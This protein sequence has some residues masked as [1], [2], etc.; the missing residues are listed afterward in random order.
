MHQI[1]VTGL[2]A[3]AEETRASSLARRSSLDKITK[4]LI[5]GLLCYGLFATTV[6]AGEEAAPSPENPYAA[7]VNGINIPLWTGT[8]P[9]W[10]PKENNAWLPFLQPFILPAGKSKGLVIVCPG[11][12][13]GGLAGH[14]GGDVAKA[15]NNLGFSAVVLHYRVTSQHQSP[16]GTGPLR[17]AGRAIRIVRAHA[18]AWGTTPEK[19]AILGFSAGGHLVGSTGVLY[20]IPDADAVNDGF[21]IVSSRP[22]AVIPCYAVLLSGEF[23][24]EG[25]M[26]NL[27]GKDPEKRQKFDIPSRVTAETPPHFIWHTAEDSAVPVENALRMADALRNAK[28]TFALHVF[29]RG[30]HG[31]GLGQNNPEAKVWPFMAATWLENVAF[32][33]P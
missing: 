24:H 11:G 19:I 4:I 3:R 14:E 16:L 2:F 8:P 21:T 9:D 30:G 25:S 27:V 22:N 33:Q 12:G 26:M 29:S 28:R 10:R 5:G 32:K 7:P 13:Y 6:T 18:N 23:T 15:F 1:K 17:D 20:T 31:M